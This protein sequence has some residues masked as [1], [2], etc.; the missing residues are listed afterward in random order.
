LALV[1]VL[2]ASFNC[3]NDVP[4]RWK[5]SVI[6]LFLESGSASSLHDVS[7]KDLNLGLSETLFGS[8]IWTF[9]KGA[10]P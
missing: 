2:A 8:I 9:N 1:E 3:K 6:V 5:N 4:N 7:K 10:D